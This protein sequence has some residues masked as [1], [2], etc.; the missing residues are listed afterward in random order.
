MISADT[1][2]MKLPEISEV[3]ASRQILLN[4]ELK[5]VDFI[6][7]GLLGETKKFPEHGER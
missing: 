3:W 4:V 6:W 7:L 2:D 1:S 5:T